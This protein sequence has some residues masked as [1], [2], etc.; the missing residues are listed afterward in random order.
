MSGTDYGSK[1]LLLNLLSS[2]M[3]AP[4]WPTVWAVGIS[5]TVPTF[6]KGSSA[7]YWN[8]TEPADPA[9]AR[10]VTTFQAAA[11][12]PVGA[13]GVTPTASVTFPTAS[14]NWGTALYAG[15]FDAGSG[16]NLWFWTPLVRTSADGVLTAGSTT[17]TSA[18]IAFTSADVGKLV[19]A[20]G[21]PIGTTIVTYTSAT[22]VVL[23]AEASASGTALPLAVAT[24]QTVN[25]ASVLSF[26]GN[27]L[28]FEQA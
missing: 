18:S 13:Y 10:Q 12:Q 21:L 5:T 28:V 2:T 16:G 23:S 15:A 27:A 22:S 24:P 17:L 8:F 6:L 19:Q 3:S 26:A 9:Y 14:V 4:T 1:Q 7:P 11:S 25:S 20:P